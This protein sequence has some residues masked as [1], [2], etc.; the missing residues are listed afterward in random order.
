MPPKGVDMQNAEQVTEKAAEF[1]HIVTKESKCLADYQVGQFSN[2]YAWAQR[3][4]DVM[5]FDT[6]S[7]DCTMKVATMFIGEDRYRLVQKKGIELA[8]ITLLKGGSGQLQT[9]IKTDLEEC[10]KAEDAT[11]VARFCLMGKNIAGTRLNGH[12]VNPQDRYVFG[13][14][15]LTLTLSA[16]DRLIETAPRK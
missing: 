9:E 15:E 2:F 13:I 10:G 1:P 8:P 16:W 6:V 5:G 11:E 12:Y 3:I 14:P 7:G 4:V